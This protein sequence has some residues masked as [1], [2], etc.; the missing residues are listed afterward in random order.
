MYTDR[1][2]TVVLLAALLL[3]S[4]SPGV[5]K[6]VSSDPLPPGARARIGSSKF[7]IPREA[8]YADLSS[9]G[10][11]IGYVDDGGDRLQT[12]DIRTG[13]GKPGCRLN[14]M[15]QRRLTFSPDGR[16]F[17]THNGTVAVWDT[18][19]GKCLAVVGG[20]LPRYSG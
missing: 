7:R 14:A 19:S 5:D 8:F 13:T 9:D 12:I 17:A 2:W 10:R 20:R 18:E 4:Q 16:R 3:S 1:R 6:D 15:P 11:S